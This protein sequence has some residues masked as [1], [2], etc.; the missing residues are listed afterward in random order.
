MLRPSRR[1]VLAASSLPVR[2]RL[3]RLLTG[4]RLP[5]LDC[6]IDIGGVD[7]DPSKA[8]SAALSGDQGCAGAEEDIEDK[9]PAL[10]DVL[11]RVRD[12]R[13]R[14]DRRV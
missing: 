13:S 12:Q 5:A 7:V 3:L 9:I 10:R 4:D 11:K 14:L 6:N 2:R 8:S 1:W